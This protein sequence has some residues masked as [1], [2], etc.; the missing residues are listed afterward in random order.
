M[1]AACLSVFAFVTCLQPL[2]ELQRGKCLRAR[3]R[4]ALAVAAATVL[5][6]SE[7]SLV[8]MARHLGCMW[9][10]SPWGWLG[11][12]GVFDAVKT[13]RG[14]FA[15]SLIVQDV[16]HCRF[17]MRRV[18]VSKQKQG[19]LQTRPIFRFNTL[20]IYFLGFSGQFF[21]LGSLWFRWKNAWSRKFSQPLIVQAV[22]HWIHSRLYWASGVWI[23]WNQGEG[24][25][26]T[27]VL[28]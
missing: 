3:R 18:C 25:I 20:Q 24:I 17:L 10:L 16:L 1:A 7:A 4:G 26:K 19:N 11:V 6:Q 9:F 23:L 27:C 13:G 15:N 8:R 5:W 28:F 21:W 22:L 2:I 12:R 14:E